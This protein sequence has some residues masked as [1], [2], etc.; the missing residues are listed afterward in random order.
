M[1][2]PD[3]LRARALAS[4]LPKEV[5]PITRAVTLLPSTDEA[6]RIVM[7]FPPDPLRG[8]VR[9]IQ[10]HL[11]DLKDR[12]TTELVQAIDQRVRERAPV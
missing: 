9:I 6:E 10:S 8:L 5:V 12:V 11:I 1:E 3:G 4:T 2:Q 7:Q